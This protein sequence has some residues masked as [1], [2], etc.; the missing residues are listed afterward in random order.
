M[1]CIEA[2]ALTYHFSEGEAVLNN[3][4]LNIPNGSIYG[5]LGANGAGKTTTMKLL[6]GLLKKQQ[7]DIRI[8]NQSLHENRQNILRRTGTFI[9]SPSL[10]GHLTAEENLK[11]WRRIYQCSASNIKEVLELVGLSST[12]KKKTAKFSLGM[13]QRLGI[14]IALLHKPQ[15][16]ILDEPTNGLDPTGMIEIRDLLKRLNKESGTTI[17]ISSHLLSEVEKLVTDV[18]IIHKGNLLFQGTMQALQARQQQATN[19]SIDTND[20]QRALEIVSRN[21]IKAS[22]QNGQLILPVTEREVMSRLN[23]Q[24]VNEQIEVYQIKIVN[25]DLESIFIDLT[26]N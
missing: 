23:E 4:D 9:E 5:F 6:L 13:K 11:I 14:A 17:L 19:I 18:G 15:L 26:K 20:G 1:N 25:N 10:Y 12:G 16:L 21:N 22:L 7:G 24:F 2:K 3:I 8:F